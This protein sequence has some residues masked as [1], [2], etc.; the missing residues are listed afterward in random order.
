MTGRSVSTTRHLVLF[1]AAS[2]G[3]IWSPSSNTEYESNVSIPLSGYAQQQSATITFKIKDTLAGTWTGFGSTVAGA[4]SI[5]SDSPLYPWAKTLT[6][7]LGN[8]SPQVTYSHN[9]VS[10]PELRTGPGRLELIALD[11][12]NNNLYTFTDPAK[13]CWFDWSFNQGATPTEAGAHCADGTSLVLFD[14]SG[15]GTPAEDTSLTIDGGV[16]YENAYGS[17]ITWR[18]AHY[19]VQGHTVHSLICTPDGMGPYPVQIINH[20]GF[21]GLDSFVALETCKRAAARGW[22]AAMSAYRGESGFGSPVPNLDDVEL[23]LGEV[24]DVLRLTELVLDFPVSDPSRVL[25]WGHSHGGCVTERAVE[26]GA[27]VTIAAAFSAPTDFNAWYSFCNQA[28]SSCPTTPSDLHNG[29]GGPP[30]NAPAAYTWRSPITFA[31]DLAVR[32]DVPFLALQG[33]ADP[34]VPPSQ[35]CAFAKAVGASSNWHVV[36]DMGAVQ[37]TAPSSPFANG[38]CNTP[39]TTL[40]WSAGSVPAGSPG[41]WTSPRNLVVYDGINHDTILHGVLVGTVAKRPWIDFENFV[42]SHG[43]PLP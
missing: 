19:T 41:A 1:A 31:A 14:N 9:G 5:S 15:V 43:L 24:I 6:P 12:N 39:A 22:V 32:K 18:A 8:W 11:P 23:C 25:M 36:N 38:S 29:L 30:S 21:G 3:C 28:N 20:G 37:A 42:T 7:G 35:A 40:T 16:H 4:S 13:D 17:A 26:Q 27:P 2:T 34:L 10:H 33:G